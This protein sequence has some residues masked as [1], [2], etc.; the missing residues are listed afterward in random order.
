MHAH[1]IQQAPFASDAIEVAHQQQAQQHFGINR[2]TT[3]R[4]V[5]APQPLP[6]EAEIH[7]AIYE[8]EQVIFGDLILKAEVVEQ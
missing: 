8:S 2:G 5:E 4:T 7:V 1:F 6:H 3:G